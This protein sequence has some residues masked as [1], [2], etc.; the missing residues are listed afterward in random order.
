ML[1]VSAAGAVYSIDADWRFTKA[2]VTIPLAQAKSSFETAGVKVEDPAFDDSATLLAVDDGDPNTDLLFKNVD[3][4]P[5][6]DGSLLAILRAKP[7]AGPVTLTAT[8]AH[9]PPLTVELK[10]VK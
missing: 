8:A 6:M 2:P 7:S 1:S 5:L 9:L 4:K 3:E 10:T